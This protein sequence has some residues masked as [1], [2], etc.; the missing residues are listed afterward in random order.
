MTLDD[1]AGRAA[2]AQA[3]GATEVCLQG[4][5]HPD[6]DGEYYIEVTRTVAEAAPGLHIH[7]FTALEVTEGA[8]RLGEPLEKYLLPAQ[9]C[10]PTDAARHRGRDPRRRSTC[11]AVP[12]QGELRGVAGSTPGRSRRRVAVPTSR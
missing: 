2:E 1:I 5:I 3:L 8:R 12:R 7:G 4:G 6:F 10:R 9:G 11:G